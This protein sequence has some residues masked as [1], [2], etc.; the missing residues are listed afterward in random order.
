MTRT[1]TTRTPKTPARRGRGR[2][3]RFT[4]TEKVGV[5][6]T[7]RRVEQLQTIAAVEGIS[8]SDALELALSGGAR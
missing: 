1:K 2:P 4:K 6:M 3:A 8:F 7:A 5:M